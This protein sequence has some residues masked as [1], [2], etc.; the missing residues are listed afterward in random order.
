MPYS[1]QR[2]VVS[3]VLIK[4]ERVHL[5][6][7]KLTL[8]PKLSVTEQLYGTL[9]LLACQAKKEIFSVYKVGFA[10]FA[11]FDLNFALFKVFLTYY[12]LCGKAY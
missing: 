9:L 11:G 6:P 8:P 4:K 5:P 3:H 7:L 2:V 12:N 1:N 10:V